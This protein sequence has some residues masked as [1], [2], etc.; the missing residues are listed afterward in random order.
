VAGKASI[1]V[2]WDVLKMI[3]EGPLKDL[4][5]IHTCSMFDDTTWG[6]SVY[7]EALP[8]GYHGQCDLVITKE[9]TNNSIQYKI[10][11]KPDVD[12]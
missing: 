1:L 6:L 10:R 4:I 8:N 2:N 11:F 12:V 9:L 5:M 3:V 7:S